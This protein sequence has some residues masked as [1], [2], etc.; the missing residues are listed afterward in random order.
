M[1]ATDFKDYYSTLGVSKTA[2]SDELKRTFRKLARKYHPD[3][4]PGDKAAEAKFKEINEAYEVLSDPDKRSKYDQFGQYWRQAGSAGSAYGGGSPFG[5]GGGDGGF[6]FSRYGNFD[7]FINELLGRFNT[8]GGDRR[9]PYGSDQGFNTGYSNPYSNPGYGTGFNP[10]AGAAGQDLE[11]KLVLTLSEAFHGVQKSLTVGGELIKDIRIPAGIKTGKKIRVKGKG[12]VSPFGQQRGDLYLM[13]EVQ[14]HGF[15]QLDGD[16]LICELPIAPDEAAL[17]ASV[18]V[19][20]PDGAVTMK[21]PAGTK[22]GQ[23]LRLRG[24]G[25]PA[26]TGRGDQMV[27]VQIVPPSGLSPAE[28]ELYEKLR[29]IRSFDPRSHLPK[30]KL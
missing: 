24:K 1:A 14:P 4:N 17:G 30:D 16:N 8:N 25:F 10:N 12:Q 26:K 11:T 20:T 21:I 15:F 2:D 28:Q 23:T 7:E 29:T 19:P 22:S 6:D 9:N 5:G 27:K 13:I 3:V 18:E